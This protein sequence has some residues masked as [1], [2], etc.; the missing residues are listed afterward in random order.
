MTQETKK[1]HKK[2]S[3]TFKT[4]E[5]I[6]LLI[7]ASIVGMAMGFLLF[8]K[9]NKKEEASEIVSNNVYLQSFIEEYKYIIDNYYDEV[10]EKEILNTALSSIL[11]SLGDPYSTSLDTTSNYFN[12]TLKGSFEGIGVEIAN[13][14]DNRIIVVNVFDSSPAQ[15][16]GIT[17]GDIIIKLN[18]EDTTNMETSV[19]VDK[20][21]EEDGNFSITVLRDNK[22]IQVE[23]K[24]EMVV[25]KSVLS[26]TFD[27]ETKKIGYIY[28]SLFAEN[29]DAQF[30]EELAKLEEDNIDALI[31]DL[32]NNTG[33]SLSTVTNIISLFLNKKHVIYQ[34]QHKEEIVKTYSNGGEDKTYKIV[35]LANEYT[36]S[37]SEVMIAALSENL[38]AYIIGKKTYGKGTVQELLT[39]TTGYQYKF[40]TKKWLTPNGTWIN[41]VGISPD[42]EVNLNDAYYSDP[43]DE[44]DN[45]LQAALNY[46]RKE[47]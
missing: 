38:N 36:A 29:T 27:D 16:A 17:A 20:L 39:T 5:I 35:F 41:D 32:R 22:E 26:K 33:G 40:T 8:S 7:I 21:K 47:N 45:Q 30:K 2:N 43:A 9:L 1:T 4:T 28:V 31:I 24:R 14:N 25:I 34:T 18:E 42:L 10:D 46:I 19:L 23:V 6:S 12:T 37:A 44:K 15:K 13:D 3:Q 11:S